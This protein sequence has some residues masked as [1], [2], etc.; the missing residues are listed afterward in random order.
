MHRSL[1]AL[2]HNRFSDVAVQA[3]DSPLTLLDTLEGGYILGVLLACVLPIVRALLD[4]TIYK[5]SQL[6]SIPVLELLSRQ[7]TAEGG[8]R[9]AD[10]TV[11]PSTPWEDRGEQQACRAEYAPLQ[12]E[13]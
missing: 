1:H 10:R 11:L 6:P 4:A 8:G 5:V 7:S 3:L 9:A 12:V 2:G 13:R